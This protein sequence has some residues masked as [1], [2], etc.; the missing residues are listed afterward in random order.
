MTFAFGP[1]GKKR[2]AEDN[3]DDHADAP[4]LK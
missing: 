2:F 1:L 3:I 4:A